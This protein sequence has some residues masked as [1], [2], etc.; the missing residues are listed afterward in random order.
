MFS[1][2]M[3]IH[4]INRRDFF[5]GDPSDDTG[6]LMI[7]D[8]KKIPHTEEQEPA[9]AV[10]TNRRQG[11]Y[12]I[13]AIL[14]IVGAGTILTI[15]TAVQT[16]H[17]MREQLL[18][19]ARIADAGINVTEVASLTGTPA[20]LASPVY[21]A[22]KRELASVRSADPDLR[23][24]YLIGQRPDG[25]FFFFVDSEPPESPD[26]S[27]PGQE[28]PEVTPLIISVYTK[29][30]AL[31]DGP[32]SDRWG[33]WVS[34]VVPV[35]DPVTGRRIAVF[36]IDEDARDWYRQVA[37]ACL[38]PVAGTLLVLVIV[39]F[40]F[41]VQRRNERERM[42]LEVSRQELRESE[43]RYRNVVED[44]TELIIRF[45]PDGTL[46]FVNDA[47]CRFF[48][49]ERDQIIGKKFTWDLPDDDRGRIS[50]HFASFSKDIPVA[51]ISHR[52][53]SSDGQ[54]SWLRWIN[55]AIFDNRGRI[56]EFQSVGHDITVQKQTEEIVSRV[57]QKLSLLSS[58]T[59]HDV[60]NQ[61]IILRGFLR[62]AGDL[63]DKPDEAREYISKAVKAALTIENQINFTR[64]YQDMGAKSPS[65]QDIRKSIISAKGSL[66]VV[67]IRIELERPEV[68][69]LADPLLEKVFY[70]LIDN[71]I[72]YGGGKMKMIRISSREVKE[73]LVIVFEDD[74]SGI[75]P[76]DKKS[77]FV[78]GF[79]KN[80][81]FGL[82]LSREILSVSGIS[83]EENGTYGEG[84]RFEIL[85]PRGNFRYPE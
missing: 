35:N 67:D 14:V 25:M 50:K 85:V 73:G 40:F 71:A 54:I 26:Y 4:W 47:Y 43:Q 74:G 37:V 38:T 45:R 51:E 57:N 15:G 13:L 76:R 60:L 17:I 61:L 24:A 83:I 16:D 32:A 23:F 56:S 10:L 20:D 72:R 81:G 65:W 41:S 46:V 19:H 82:F 52:V 66:P 6:F 78:R 21:Q 77:L 44:Q 39:L 2:G 70:N 84:A 36:G 68:E 12:L 9:G 34:A 69:V 49:L 22:I 58:I 31:T 48:H 18:T 80:T 29:G 59:R 42:Y 63:A 55:R 79:G 1:A 75:S 62:L 11:R 5:Q 28:Y 33:T 7:P 3:T 8:G 53:R 30:D 27:P 64:D